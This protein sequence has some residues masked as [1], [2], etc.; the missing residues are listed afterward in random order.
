MDNKRM[1]LGI[2]M[3]LV[4]LAA[5]TTSASAGAIVYFYNPDDPNNP[6][7]PIDVQL[8]IGE[9]VTI[10]IMGDVDESTS[11]IILHQTGV[12]Y[13]PSVIN[14]TF[15]QPAIM[16]PYAYWW[17]QYF[18]GTYWSDETAP[19]G[20]YIWMVGTQRNNPSCYTRASNP[21]LPA[22]FANLTIECVGAGISPLI[23]THE[24]RHE[25]T[26]GSSLFADC[27]GDMIPD[28]T[29]T[30]CND[31]ISGGTPET[32]ATSLDLGWN[33]ISL[34]LIPS[35][36]STSAVLGNGD[37]TIVYDEVYSYD[38]S[39]NQFVDVTSGT[40][41]TGVGYFVDVTTAGTWSYEGFGDESL[42]IEL[43]QGLNCV[44]WTN[45]SA[46]LPGALDSIAGDYRYVACWNTAE[47]KYE[48]YDPVGAGE[49]PEF[50]DFTPMERGVGYF[51]AATTGCTLTYP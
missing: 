17:S 49:G 27:S 10:Q 30:W 40:M 22:P 38:A 29:I 44:G 28:E 31:V 3:I 12:D 26:I 5:F 23:F 13:D 36:S 42:D 20:A 32:F 7:D 48:V 1:V 47:Q 16:P 25:P 24:I 8:E 14:I 18:G 46:D 41:E 45:T 11:G 19:L 39:S 2:G 21:P 6:G 51:I 43:S 33:L 50:I 15:S 37:C 4:V 9:I 35:D 34:P